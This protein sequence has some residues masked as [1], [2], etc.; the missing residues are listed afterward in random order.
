MCYT[1][2]LKGSG[3]KL[4]QSDMSSSYI[5]KH[6]ASLTSSPRHGDLI[7]M[8]DDSNDP[9]VY[10]IAIFD[11]FEGDQVYFI[12]ST[13]QGKIN[14]VSKRHYSRNSKKIKAYGIMK[15]KN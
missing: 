1:Y 15:L 11:R 13:S 12:D 8:G 14:G 4:L 9:S 5:Y 3:Y 6:A 2:A 10:H 7:F